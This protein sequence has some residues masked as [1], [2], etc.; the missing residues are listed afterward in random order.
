MK[1]NPLN[2]IVYDILLLLCESYSSLR[3]NP[4]VK[5]AMEHCFPD[6]VEWKTE[7]T[8]KSVDRQTEDL[9]QQWRDEENEEVREKFSNIFPE[10]KVST[11]NEQG[12]VLI[13]HKPDGSKAQDLLGGAMEI[14]SPWE[15]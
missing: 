13:E 12:A 10:S 9:K 4:W 1:Y 15:G 7:R 8:M 11:H 5:Q 2:A 14:K 3:L 6:W